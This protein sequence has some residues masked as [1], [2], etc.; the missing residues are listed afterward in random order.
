MPKARSYK[1]EPFSGF[2]KQSFSVLKDDFVHEKLLTVKANVESAKGG[3]NLKE[4]LNKK[5]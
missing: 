1:N 5:G 4:S 3:V 2:E